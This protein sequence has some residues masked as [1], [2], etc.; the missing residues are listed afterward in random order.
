MVAWALEGIAKVQTKLGNQEAAEGAVAKAV[1]IRRASVTT[2]AGT[3]GFMKELSAAEAQ[4]ATAVAK[5]KASPSGSIDEGPRRVKKALAAALEKHGVARVSRQ[6][7]NR[8]S[9]GADGFATPEAD[10]VAQPSRLSSLEEVVDLVASSRGRGSQASTRGR[11]RADTTGGESSPGSRDRANTA[12]SNASPSPMSM[13]ASEAMGTLRESVGDGDGDGD[14]D[15]PGEAERP[16][17]LLLIS[18]AD[19]DRSKRSKAGGG[20]AAAFSIDLGRFSAL[21]GQMHR[22]AWTGPSCGTRLRSRRYLRRRLMPCTRS[23][24]R[25]D[26][27]RTARPSWCRACCR[28]RPLPSARGRVLGGDQPKP[29]RRRRRWR[30]RGGAATHRGDFF[31]EHALLEAQAAGAPAAHRRHLRQLLHLHLHRRRRRRSARRRCARLVVVAVAPSSSLASLPKQVV[32]HLRG[33]KSE[34]D[35]GALTSD[36]LSSSTSPT[37]A[38]QYGTV[39]LMRHKSRDKPIALK[40]MRG[41]GGEGPPVPARPR[42][43]AHGRITAPIHRAAALRVQGLE[44]ADDGC[45]PCCPHP[46]PPPSSPPSPPSPPPPPLQRWITS[47]GELWS[48]LAKTGGR[49]PRASPASSSA[50]S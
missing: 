8:A 1:G 14:S 2:N 50:R 24:L 21:V 47:R 19:A 45:V 18:S 35:D 11:S 39:C 23:S 36:S 17:D 20:G 5:L 33:L 29:L 32:G 41:G 46:S 49:L 27:S 28:R 42:R 7:P 44:A 37:S 9:A 38:G 31:G 12:A 30:R 26:P 13:R 43:A 6:S 10:R 34:Y 40:M 25:S 3:Q 16:I 15:G 22:L 48:I 4:H